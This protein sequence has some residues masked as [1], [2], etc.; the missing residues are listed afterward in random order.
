M[1]HALQ[2]YLIREAQVSKETLQPM[3]RPLFYEFGNRY[4]DVHD[5]YL[6]GRSLLIAP[7]LEEKQ[8]RRTVILPEGIWYDLFS[9]ETISGPHT[10]EK[11]YSIDRIGIFINTLD[12]EFSRLKGS[13][14]VL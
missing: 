3:M 6:L 10:M 13:L 2:W 4:S 8:T 14:M 12:E 1:R 11:E 7:I 9:Q 5:Q